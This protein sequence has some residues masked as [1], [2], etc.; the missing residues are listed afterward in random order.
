MPK[1]T[2]EEIVKKA[3]SLPELPA[4]AL[5]VSRL[6]DNENT[7]AEMLAEIIRV[8]A[9][10]TGQILRLCNSATYG[11]ARKI[12][13]V[14]E[15]I[16]ILGFATLRSMVYTIIAKSALDKPIPGYGLKEGD[17]WQNSVTCAIY[18]KHIAQKMKHPNPELPYTGALLRDIGMLVLGEYVGAN[19][20]E[21]EKLTLTGRMDFVQAEGEVLGFNHCIIG[22]RVAEKWNLPPVLI[23][24]IKYHHKPSR[25]PSHTLPDDFRIITLVHLADAMTRMVGYGSG[26]D[27]LM[28][29][30]D[31]EALAKVNITPQNGFME[32]LIGELVDLGPVIRDLVDSMNPSKNK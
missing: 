30:M 19:Y 29:A 28:Y 7:S 13:T 18:A 1:P 3:Q 6:L 23:N 31:W 15:A 22:S 4:A 2:I 25:L 24:T 12:S 9:S 17:L 21:I 16:A 20:A 14:K 27:G 11:F 26:N 10:L 8:D 32:V 5:Q